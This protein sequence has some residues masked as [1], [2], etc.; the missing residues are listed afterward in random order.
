[1]GEGN[2]R[3][4]TLWRLNHGCS[5]DNPNAVVTLWHLNPDCPEATIETPR[6]DVYTIPFIH[7]VS[8]VLQNHVLCVLYI[9]SFF[10]NI[11][12]FAHLR[13]CIKKELLKTQN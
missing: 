6:C 10:K 1:M 7:A 2:C 12:A 5:E 8:K 11:K 9:L 3:D 4:V 13:L